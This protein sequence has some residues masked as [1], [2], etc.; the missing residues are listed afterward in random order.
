MSPRSKPSFSP[1]TGAGADRAGRGAALAMAWS[2]LVWVAIGLVI[3][4]H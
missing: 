3:W 1:A 4:A 2:A